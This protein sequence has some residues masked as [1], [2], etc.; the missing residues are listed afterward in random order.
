MMRALACS[1]MCLLA[2]PYVQAVE[3][4]R[5][6][7]FSIGGFSGSDTS[8]VAIGFY[9]LRP[10]S[11]GWYI[12]GTVSSRVD[13]DGD[14]F[15]PI[16]GD[17]RVDAETESVTANV[18]LT[19][20]LGPFSPYFG[21]GITQISEYG[22]YRAPSAAFWYEEKDDTE[23]NFNV[24]L[25]LT[26]HQNLGLDLGANSANDELVLGLVWRFR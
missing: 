11:I 12:N 21:L 9:S 26:L 7:H 15:R 14:D 1:L 4:D 5:S 22:L 20:A 18:G 10:K 24:G 6:R 3:D 13:K 8:G 25:L 17:I 2:A 16:P 19:F 23:A